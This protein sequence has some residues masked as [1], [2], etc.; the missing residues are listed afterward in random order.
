ME[1]LIVVAIIAAVAALVVPF[2]KSMRAKSRQVACLNNLK[3]IGVGIESYLQDHSD[4]MPDIAA[5]RKTKEEDVLVLETALAD[6]IENPEIYHC[7]KIKKFF[8][9]LEAATFGT[10]RR[11]A[12]ISIDW[13]FSPSLMIQV[14]CPWSRTRKNGIQENPA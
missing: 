14:A 11:A 1:L 2:G 5:G 6:Y 10:P 8:R 3:E 7:P 12:R 13:N 4:T 9:R